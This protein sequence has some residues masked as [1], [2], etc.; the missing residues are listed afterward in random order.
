MGKSKFTVT[1]LYSDRTGD[2]HFEDLNLPLSSSGEIGFLSERIDAKTVQFRRVNP[3]YDYDFHNAPKRQFIFL[4]DG[5][6]QIETS[7]GDVRTFSAGDVLL[8][9]D[10]MGKGHRTKNLTAVKR[11]SV[12]VEIPEDLDIHLLTDSPSGKN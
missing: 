3:E 10:T 12:F 11:R 1:R 9:E 7:L 5:A 6:I 4:L 2:T 8:V